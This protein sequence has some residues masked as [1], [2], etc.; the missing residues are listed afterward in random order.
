VIHVSISLVFILD[1]DTPIHR[2]LFLVEVSGPAI[3]NFTLLCLL[4][5]ITGLLFFYSGTEPGV[6]HMCTKQH[7]CRTSLTCKLQGFSLSVVQQ[8]SFKM[9]SAQL[10]LICWIALLAGNSDESE[11]ASTDGTTERQIQLEEYPTDESTHTERQQSFDYLKH[12]QYYCKK[13]NIIQVFPCQ[14]ARI[15]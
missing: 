4:T 12:W 8:V 9:K 2:L 5:V 1:E 13:C 3:A 14:L 15:F 6:E 7:S 11:W 10:C